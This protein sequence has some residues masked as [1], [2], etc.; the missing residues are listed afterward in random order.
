MI[1]LT[2]E[3]AVAKDNRRLAAARSPSRSRRRWLFAILL[4]DAKRSSRDPCGRQ[5]AVLS[6]DGALSEMVAVV[7][8]GRLKLIV[9]APALHTHGGSSD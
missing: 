2:S 4:G 3:G 9:S 7:Q 1:A 5:P 8:L 6:L